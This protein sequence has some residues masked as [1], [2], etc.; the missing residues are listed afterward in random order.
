M[1]KIFGLRACLVLLLSFVLVMMLSVFFVSETS[2]KEPAASY[3]ILFIGD[4][5]TYYNDLPSAL[6]RTVPELKIKTV[7]MT[8]G[9]YTL[10]KFLSEKVTLDAIR[11]GN[12]DFVILQENSQRSVKDKKKMH[13]AIRGLAAEIKKTKAQTILFMP[14]AREDFPK[15][16]IPLSKAYIEIGKELD[17]KV[18][19]VGLAWE[20]ALK[21]N[22]KLSLYSDDKSHPSRPGTY[23]AVCTLYATLTG[24]SPVGLSV[25]GFKRLG[26]ERAK[27]L[28]QIA[29][30]TYETQRLKNTAKDS[31]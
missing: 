15:M 13:D 30:K 31:H 5:Y 20:S 10:E 7:S 21:A 16:I 3:R 4:S 1:K 9:A 2:A 24:K 11:K 12:F 28:Q 26:D 8:R 17:I 6:T 29:W 19:P 22:P 27:F 18:S 25:G 23:L 14:W